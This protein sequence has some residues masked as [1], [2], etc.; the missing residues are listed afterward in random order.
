MTYRSNKEFQDSQ[1]VGI[2]ELTIYL[3]TINKWGKLL[4]GAKHC[5]ISDDETAA[6]LIKTITDCYPDKVIRVEKGGEK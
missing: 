6:A 3:D 2:P 1:K 4:K 5:T